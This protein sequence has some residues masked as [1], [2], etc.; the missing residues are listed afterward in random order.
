MPKG[1]KDGGK[2]KRESDLTDNP[3]SSE[4]EAAAVKIQARARGNAARKKSKSKKKMEKTKSKRKV[5][6]AEEMTQDEAAT[7]IQAAHR[8]KKGRKKSKM[9]KKLKEKK[10][11]KLKKIREAAEYEAAIAIEN[12]VSL[13][14]KPGEGAYV[15]K[16]SDRTCTDKICCLIFILYWFGMCFLIHFATTYGDIDRLVRPRDMDANSCGLKTGSGD[17]EVD[18]EGFRQLYLP[19]PADETQQ[20][21]V[22][23]CPGSS[24]GT[25]SGAGGAD[26]PAG[27]W[28]DYR[29]KS[30]SS[31]KS[32]WDKINQAASLLGQGAEE[33]LPNS[34]PWYSGE[35]ACIAQG[36]CSGAVPASDGSIA[37]DAAGQPIPSRDVGLD[38]C[39]DFGRCM[40]GTVEIL[41][42]GAVLIGGSCVRNCA[43]KTAQRTVCQNSRNTGY[44]FQQY[45]FTP[46]AWEYDETDDN[47]FICMPREAACRSARIP[48]TVACDDEDYPP[49]DFM[50]ASS[51]GWLSSDGPCW[52]PVF[53]SEELLYRCVPSMLTDMASATAQA[54]GQQSVQYMKDLQ[55]YWRIIPFG[56]FIA[57]LAAFAWI[58]FLG[59]FAYY[60]IWATVYGVEI[61]LPCISAAAFYKLGAIPTRSCV[62]SA[63]SASAKK[64]AE[65]L[66][67]DISSNPTELDLY[68]NELNDPNMLNC[69]AIGVEVGCASSDTED[70]LGHCTYEPGL[71]VEI[72]PEVQAAMD[73]ANTSQ[74]YTYYMAY[75]SLVAW[76]VLGVIFFIFKQRIMISIGVIEEASDAFLDIPFAV[77]MP[78][79][80]L[81]CSIPVSAFCCVACFLLL[82]LRRVAEN[83]MLQY[84][85]ADD[86]N[87]PLSAEEQELWPEDCVLFGTPSI[88]QG[89]FFAQLFGWVWTVQWFLSIQYCGIAGAISKW[90]FTPE[91]L[92]THEKKISAVLLSHS[93]FRTLRF[94]SGTA[95]LGS[96]IVAVVIFVKFV[97]IYMVNQMQA[98][99]PENKMIQLLGK[100]LKLLIM[101]VEK[102]IRFMGHL[103][104]IETAIY[105]TNFCHSLYKAV[106]AL[107]K[108]VVRFSF[109]T[110]FSKLV[111]IL[112]KLLVV[113][114]A[115]GLAILCLPLLKSDNFLEGAELNMT[116]TTTLPAQPLPLV[117]LALVCF[118]AITISIN[119]MGIYETAIDTIMVSFL[120][121]E[122]ENDGNGQVSFA[123]GPLKDFMSGTKG[124]ADATERYKKSLIAAKSDKLK[125]QQEM[126]KD[127]MKSDLTPKGGNK[128]LKKERKEKRKVK[129]PKLTKEEKK[130]KKDEFMSSSQGVKGME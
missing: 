32:E 119:I 53:P 88:L 12:D 73:E 109:V 129:G 75:G 50:T 8:A 15:R 17:G 87:M 61:L 57:V 97:L 110:L 38:A 29:Q 111:L 3:L 114:A 117:P 66:A 20:I 82:S 98:Q 84:C 94:H 126:E 74:E 23:G 127:M 104:Y 45:D 46:Y 11:A 108:N 63:A 9:A 76:V 25:C 7:K 70:C 79:V 116:V 40:N 81:L 13:L 54:E 34:L 49:K 67:A 58:I 36:D 47:L 19:N 120:E 115:L 42:A 43:W 6:K 71:Y 123:S 24:K 33:Y 4:Q 1:G 65:C 83:G 125:A 107:V 100:C 10:E 22:D 121:D 14:F 21:C 96:F 62:A 52:M 2:K 95:A 92:E 48:T 5:K 18:L 122:K 27:A 89:M 56:G 55:D 41:P 112:G 85:L 102:F 90:Y 86:P 106:K 16:G 118:F 99:A 103:A 39:T 72:P 68:P 101:C 93:V 124:I 37:K 51:K 59:K 78:L 105:G 113:A 80:V 128:K 26:D 77:F 69:Q 35:D 91:N 31:R 44:E 64:V 60:L 30:F 28:D 130:R